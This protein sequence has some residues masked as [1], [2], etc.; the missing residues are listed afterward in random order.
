[1]EKIKISTKLSS[2]APY[3]KHEG[4]H[5]QQYSENIYYVRAGLSTLTG[6]FVKGKKLNARIVLV[7]SKNKFLI[8]FLGNNYIMDSTMH[9][10]RFD[11][12]TVSVEE[13]EPILKLKI[14]PLNKA[15]PLHGGK[16]DIKI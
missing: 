7:L 16:M 11:E 5:F 3:K 15:R 10:D 14:L 4:S 13:T 8:R 9:F 12:V 6:K 1:M 2:Y